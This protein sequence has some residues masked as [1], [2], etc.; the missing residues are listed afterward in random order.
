MAKYNVHLYATVRRQFKDVE[1]ESHEEAIKQAARTDEY[2]AWRTLMQAQ[3]D[4]PGSVGADAEDINYAVVDVVGDTDF[5]NTKRF[6][7]SGDPLEGT[8]DAESS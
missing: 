2:E 6:G 1:A 4:G 8:L 3:E 5:T 7:C